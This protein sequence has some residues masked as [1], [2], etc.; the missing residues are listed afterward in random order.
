MVEINEKLQN[1][2]KSPATEALLDDVRGFNGAIGAGLGAA[3]SLQT[4]GAV[5]AGSVTTGYTIGS[6]VSDTLMNGTLHGQ[7]AIDAQAVALQVKFILTDE[8]SHIKDPVILQTFKDQSQAI[9]K[10]LGSK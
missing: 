7:D 6:T 8:G 4:G 9:L 5:T 2:E 1:L 3:L 10:A